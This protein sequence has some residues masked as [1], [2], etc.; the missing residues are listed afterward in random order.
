MDRIGTFIRFIDSAAKS[1]L[2]SYYWRPGLEGAVNAEDP[3][4]RRLLAD[5]P[6]RLRGF[7]L[8]SDTSARVAAFRTDLTGTSMTVS[9]RAFPDLDLQT[10]LVGNF[11]VWNV[12]AAVTAL[13]GR[14]K[15]EAIVRGVAS[16]PQVPGRLERYALPNGA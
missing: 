7:S 2:F 8:S 16:I 3:Y 4:G 5:F 15:D 1:L 11:N 13:R 9:M 10:P 14:V 12:L 6:G